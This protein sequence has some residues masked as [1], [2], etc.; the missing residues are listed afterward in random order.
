M[1]LRPQVTLQV[2]EKWAI[3]FVGPINPPSRRLGARYIITSKKYLT[4]WDEATP[5]K[6]CNVLF[7]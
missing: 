3:E 4:K 5:V 2:F 1:P 6:D 7:I